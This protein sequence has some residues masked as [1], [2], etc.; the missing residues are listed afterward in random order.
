MI[1]NPVPSETWYLRDLDGLV[2]RK[3]YRTTVPSVT[4]LKD[5]IH[6]QGQVLATE[7][8]AGSVQHA[9]LDHL[10]TIR[11]WT[12]M[13]AA[14]PKHLKYSAFGEEIGDNAVNRDHQF[15]GHER[16]RLRSGG[17]SGDLTVDDQMISTGG[18][19]T[20]CDELSSTNTTVTSTEEVRFRAGDLITLSEFGVAPAAVF[21]AE[22]DA[23]L[24]SDIQDLDYMHARYCSPVL[25]RFVAVDPVGGK[26]TAPQSWNRY[27]YVLGNPLKYTDPF[28]LQAVC[29]G[30]DQEEIRCFDEITATGV[31]PLF[32]LYSREFGYSSPFNP[33]FSYYGG[34]E[35]PG[36][37]DPNTLLIEGIAQRTRGVPIV[38]EGVQGLFFPTQTDVGGREL[39]R[40]LGLELALAAAPPGRVFKLFKRGKILIKTHGSRHLVGTALKQEVVEEAI[41]RQITA[42]ASL[43]SQ[44]GQ[45]YG[46][47]T[48]GGK[49]IEYRAFTLPD[50]TISVGTYYPP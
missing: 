11:L 48:I 19:F 47:V 6:R 2:L 49:V 38:A 37:I 39:V 25:G 45:F 24:S 9:H 26:Q 28:G 5:T 21:V 20:G 30:T 40:E 27:A 50:G 35:R 41:A 46:R 31:A 13:V 18:T 14:S 23:N 7:D 10:G 8:Q 1:N 34:Q 3:F 42:Q 43:A 4:W 29:P 17:C 44:T 15:T 22:I 16:D 12:D 33:E 32:T 36:S